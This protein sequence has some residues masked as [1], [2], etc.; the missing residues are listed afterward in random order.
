MIWINSDTLVEW[1]AMADSLTGNLI[2]DASVGGVLSDTSGNALVSFAFS[3]TGSG[4]YLGTITAAQAA[5]LATGTQ[6]LLTVTATRTEGN[7]TER[8]VVRTTAD[9]RGLD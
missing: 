8:R 7:Q 6:Y 5:A 4:N 9:Y 2:D 3:Y 1:S